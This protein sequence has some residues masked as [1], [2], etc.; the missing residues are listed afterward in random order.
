M[1][2]IVKKLSKIEKLELKL[3]FCSSMVIYNIKNS[4]F[5]SIKTWKIISLKI[6]LIKKILNVHTN[7]LCC[8]KMHFLWNNLKFELMPK[9][10]FY[11]IKIL[12]F[13]L[14]IGPLNYA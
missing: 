13:K 4:S 12:K 3:V 11:C 9:N 1:S 5:Y 2:K 6:K 10:E 14:V 7:N 8:I